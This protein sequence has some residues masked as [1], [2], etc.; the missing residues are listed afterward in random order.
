MK[1]G[2]LSSQRIPI[3]SRDQWLARRKFDVTASAVGAVFGCHPYLSPLRLYIE[4]QG[5]IDLPDQGDSGVLRRGRIYEPA[6]AA[7]VVE[8]RP[9]WRLEK[10]Q[11]Y[12]HDDALGIGATP[13][14]FIHGDARGIGVLQT[15]TTIPSVYERE[16]SDGQ[17]PRYITL[18][19]MTEAIMTSAA[20]SAVACLVF[21]PFDTPLTIAELE[22]DLVLE[23]EICDRVAQFWKDIEA[24]REPDVDYGSDRALLAA[25][26]PREEPITIDLSTDNEVVA[27]LIER[28]GLKERIKADEQRCSEIE[29]LVMSRMASAAVATVP[30]FTV[31]WKV[32]HRKGYTVEPS[33]ARVLNIRTKREAA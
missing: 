24:G 12:F 29:T 20:F 17:P 1:E 3:T 28:R 11:E 21:D 18:Q 32:Q 5:L 26:M 2:E 9:D 27:G 25:L 10:C 13:D 14:F 22:R 6:V 31:T 33:E 7:A 19:A 15:K 23:Q 16:W 4:K 8:Q 30:G